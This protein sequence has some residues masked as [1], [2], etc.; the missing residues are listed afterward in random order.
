MTSPLGQGFVTFLLSWAPSGYG[1]NNGPVPRSQKN[2]FKCTN[3]I[4]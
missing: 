2:A 3:Y 1:D 4:K